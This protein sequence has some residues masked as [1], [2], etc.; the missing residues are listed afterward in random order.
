MKRRDFIALLGGTVVGWPLTVCAEQAMG[1]RRIGALFDFLAYDPQS[2]IG[3]TAFEDGLKKRG[4]TV[5]GN[6]RIV[7]R[8]A[9][10]EM[11][12]RKS[13]H[14]LVSL[15][16]DVILAVGGPS[17]TALQE[18]TSTLP[19]VFINTNDPITHGFIKSM[20]HPGGNF[21]GLIEFEPSIGVEW[22][23]LLNQIAPSVKRVAVIQDPALVGWRPL[24]NAIENA[25]PSFSMKVSRV[26]VRDGLKM[27]RFVSTFASNPNGGLI[28]T[29][30]TFSVIIRE[31]IIALAASNKLPAIYFNQLF[32]AEGGLVS[33]SPDTVDQYRR[34][35]GYV[36]R[37]L[38]GEKPTD[39]AVRGPRKFELVVNLKAAQVIGL[40]I[41]A[42]VLAVADRVIK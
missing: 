19:I 29:P 20:E 28:V 35:A 23:R 18:V 12:L 37:I 22:L 3:S 24:L 2:T 4:W 33:Y 11:L 27:E 32:A 26:D 7:Y 15:N 21:T 41:P 10:Y 16:P 5:G 13:A 1:V 40:T 6:L 39:M 42:S 9:N 34:A 36:D 38:K 17:A 31:R 30:T 25:A 8:Y 14:E